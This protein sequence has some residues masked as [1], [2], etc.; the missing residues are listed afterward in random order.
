[1][2]YADFCPAV[3]MLNSLEVKATGAADAA[4]LVGLGKNRRKHPSASCSHQLVVNEF[5]IYTALV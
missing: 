3:G 1:M 5:V 4:A 2:P